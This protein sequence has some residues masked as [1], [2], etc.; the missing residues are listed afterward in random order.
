VRI[1]EIT[2]EGV[3]EI[4]FDP[5]NFDYG[6]T[7]LDPQKMKDLGYAGFRIHY[8]LNV[9]DYKDEVMVF[10]GASYFRALGK[11]QR[12]GL[13]ARGLAIDTGLMS[14]EEFPRFVEFWLERPAPGAKELVIYGLLDS[15][16]MAGAYRFVLKPG[17]ETVIEVKAQL[18]ARDKVQKVGIAPLTSM[19]FF[20][21]NH[22]PPIDDFRPEVHDSDGLSIATGT[23]E[24]IWRP[25]INPKRLLV[26]SFATTNPV[27][28]GLMQ[29]DVQFTS[30]ED[31]EA[32]YERRPS[33]WVRPKGEWGAGRV[34]LVQLPTPDETNDNVVVFWTPDKLPERGQ[35]LE[36]Q[37]EL[38]WQSGGGSQPSLAAVSQT[39]HGH[40]HVRKNEKVIP[41]NAT[42]HIDFDGPVL[43]KLPPETEVEGIVTADANGELLAVNTYRNDVTAGWRITVRVRR[44]DEAKPVELRAYL[45]DGETTLSETWSYILPPE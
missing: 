12:Y 1:N 22:R 39:R 11:G 38:V 28:F 5:A 45:R 9:P 41:N 8:P 14:G 2:A 23:G 3:Q 10:L 36:I 18:F 24:W 16:S 19:Y 37:Y 6:Q 43:Q 26:T 42:L 21:E 15:K 17:T 20:G 35:P 7:K 31:L 29:R 40:G 33:V 27:G 4:K 34:E 44:I 25:L 32:R 13:S 30:Y